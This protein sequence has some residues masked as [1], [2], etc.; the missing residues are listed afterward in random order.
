MVEVI[1]FFSQSI[2]KII[3]KKKIFLEI[4][5]V[6]LKNKLENNEFLFIYSTFSS[7]LCNS[8]RYEREREYFVVVD[9]DD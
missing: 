8:L 3:Y 1:F 4:F 9:D 6:T 5:F 7:L 2:T